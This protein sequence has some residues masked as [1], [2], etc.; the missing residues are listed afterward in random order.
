LRNSWALAVGEEYTVLGL[1]FAFNSPGLGT[2]TWIEYENPRQGEYVL[3][4]PL[5]LFEVIDAALSPI[6]K[7]RSNPE[8]VTFWPT[9]FHSPGY[10]DRLSNGAKKE[11]A[12]LRR[13]KTE[14]GAT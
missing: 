1:T 4:A 14:L 13:L 2:G 3:T 6:W 9:A 10:H 5:D 8:L 11:L 7:F 12:E